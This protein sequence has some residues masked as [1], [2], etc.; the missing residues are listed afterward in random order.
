MNRY[1]AI[2]KEGISRVYGFGETNYEAYIQCEIALREYCLKHFKTGRRLFP[3]NYKIVKNMIYKPMETDTDRRERIK[4]TNA[5][6][7]RVDAQVKS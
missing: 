6:I 5:S 2:D 1:D 3:K 4:E 7:Q